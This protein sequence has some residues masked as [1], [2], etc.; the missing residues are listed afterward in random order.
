MRV[1]PVPVELG[2]LFTYHT[3]NDSSQRESEESTFV[4]DACSGSVPFRWIPSGVLPNRRPRL[5]VSFGRWYGWCSW[6]CCWYWSSGRSRLWRRWALGLSFVSPIAA[7]RFEEFNHRLPPRLPLDRKPSFASRPSD[8]GLPSARTKSVFE[9]DRRG[10][11]QRRV[12]SLS[13]CSRSCPP[14]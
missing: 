11:H 7:P 13:D 2:S 14:L 6:Y 3:S 5:R 12:Q 8:R 9:L 4:P 1:T 10:L